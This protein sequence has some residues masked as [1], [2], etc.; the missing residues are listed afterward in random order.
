[1]DLFNE[2]KQLAS[3]EREVEEA[4]THMAKKCETFALQLLEV[5]HLFRLKSLQYGLLFHFVFTKNMHLRCV[6]IC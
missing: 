3:R 4:Y 6:E 2:L 1:M 5:N